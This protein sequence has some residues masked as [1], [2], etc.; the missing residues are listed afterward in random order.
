MK[1]THDVFSLESD[2]EIPRNNQQISNYSQNY[3]TSSIRT[4]DEVD[5]I[6]FDLYEQDEVTDVEVNDEK[7]PFIQEVLMRHGKQICITAYLQATISDTARSV[8]Q[9]SYLACYQ[10]TQHLTLPATISPKLRSST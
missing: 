3:A 9:I 2:A 4:D 7:Q 1:K 8:R 6:I 10:S 5:T